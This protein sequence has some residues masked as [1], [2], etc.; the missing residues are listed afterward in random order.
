MKPATKDEQLTRAL[1]ALPRKRAR[2]GFTET[3]LARLPEAPPRR[4]PHP[5]RL[6]LAAAL[7]LALAL[8]PLA[9]RRQDA[10]PTP[11]AA[12]PPVRQAQLEEIRRQQAELARELAEL[13]ELAAADLPLVYLGGDEETDLVL[14]LDRLARRRPPAGQVRPASLETGGRY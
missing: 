11:A 10:G 14:D 13:K 2:D 4:F 6:A 7:G 5:G 1:R 8:A 9:L 3:L 12:G